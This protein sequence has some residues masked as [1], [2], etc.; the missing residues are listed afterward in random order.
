MGLPT[1]PAVAQVLHVE[2][3]S[4]REVCM[5]HH[6]DLLKKIQDFFTDL[7]LGPLWLL[8]PLIPLIIYLILKIWPDAF[9]S[10]YESRIFIMFNPRS[11]KLHHAWFM[12]Y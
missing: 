6:K 8:F 10:I 7:G 12:G 5:K 9:T 11:K 2:R 3:V 1:D 4:T